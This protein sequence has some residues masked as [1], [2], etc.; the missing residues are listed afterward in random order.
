M[1]DEMLSISSQLFIDKESNGDTVL[2]K[3]REMSPDRC[4]RLIAVALANELHEVM[5]ACQDFLIFFNLVFYCSWL[6]KGSVALACEYSR[7]SFA[8]ATTFDINPR[9][10]V[11]AL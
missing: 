3:F 8:P 4:A 5:M 1:K 9:C 7:L 2:A 11:T 6:M 10:T